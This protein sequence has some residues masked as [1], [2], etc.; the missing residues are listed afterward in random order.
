MSQV[1][2]LDITVTQTHEDGIVEI[3]GKI[4]PNWIKE[5]ILIHVCIDECPGQTCD[6]SVQ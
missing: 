3:L 4:R 2:K 1:L 6:K 5:H